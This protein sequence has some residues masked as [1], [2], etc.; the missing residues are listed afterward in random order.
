MSKQLTGT[1]ENLH[2]HENSA[3]GNLNA[4]LPRLADGVLRVNS[5][6]LRLYIVARLAKSVESISFPCVIVRQSS[7][8][9]ILVGRAWG[10]K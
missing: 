2:Y 6:Y 5:I 10:E 3:E 4:D 8:E 7:A 9:A 1:R